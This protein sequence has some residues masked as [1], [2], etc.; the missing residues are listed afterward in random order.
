ML[1]VIGYFS[2]LFPG[3]RQSVKSSLLSEIW[4]DDPLKSHWSLMARAYTLIR[5]NFRI[6]D[7]TLPLFIRLVAAF[8]GIP[9]PK[10]Y[11]L[12][13][14]FTVEEHIDPERK[15]TISGPNPN[16]RIIPH[17]HTV[18]IFDIVEFLQCHPEYYMEQYE[19]SIWPYD[20]S[21][22]ENGQMAVRIDPDNPAIDDPLDCIFDERNWNLDIEDTYSVVDD[23]IDPTRDLIY[24][25]AIDVESLIRLEEE[26]VASSAGYRARRNAGLIPGVPPFPNYN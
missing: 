4:S 21:A 1:T 25:P 23:S 12:L 9:G 6:A 2:G 17:V 26:R 22:H 7:P 14:G 3:V 5:D 11:L 24:W 20:T 16:E 19:S 13:C 18:T 10:N 15:Y 8:M